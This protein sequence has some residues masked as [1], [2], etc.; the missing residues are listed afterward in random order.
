MTWLPYVNTLP[1]GSTFRPPQDKVM[2]G[3]GRAVNFMRPTYAR[4][5]GYT[6]QHYSSNPIVSVQTNRIV[7]GFSPITRP[8]IPASR[9][10]NKPLPTKQ[11]LR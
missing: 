8:T 11:Q 10:T 6:M 3:L 2:R 7:T 9:T 5:T 1:T 4:Q